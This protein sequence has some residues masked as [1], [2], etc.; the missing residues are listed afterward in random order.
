MYE[1][2]IDVLMDGF[3]TNGPHTKEIHEFIN[4]HH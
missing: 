3:E 2:H 4:D 1:K